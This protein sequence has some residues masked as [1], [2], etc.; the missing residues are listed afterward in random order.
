M[1][2]AGLRGNRLSARAFARIGSGA[3]LL[4]LLSLAAY[5][6][7]AYW[8][9]QAILA[10][11]AIKALGLGYV[12]T[13][14][15]GWRVGVPVFSLLF[16]TTIPTAEELLGVEEHSR[17]ALGPE[18]LLF[19]AAG[20]GAFAA[21][22]MGA[23][24]I[25]A[26]RAER[27]S[28]VRAPRPAGPPP[29]FAWLM[30]G[31]GAWG[32]GYTMVFGYYGGAAVSDAGVL[33]GIA[34]AAAAFFAAGLAVAWTEGIATGN[35]R[36]LKIAGLGTALHALV[37]LLSASKGAALFP[38]LV[39]FFC[40]VN[41]RAAVPWKPVAVVVAAYVLVVFPFATYWRAQLG[42]AG[43]SRSEFAKQGIDILLEG[44]WLGNEDLRTKAVRSG[45]RGL[46]SVY[47][48]I[49][50]ETGIVA[51]HEGGDTY[52]LALGV[53]V[54]RL[55]WP[56]KPDHNGANLVGKKY[57][58]I[59]TSD[60]ATGIAPTWAGEAAM[61]F[62]PWGIPVFFAL[63]G[64][65]AAWMDGAATRSA[66]LWFAAWMAPVAIFGQEGLVAGALLPGLRNALAAMLLLAL[67]RRFASGRSRGPA[68]LGFS[69]GARG[70]FT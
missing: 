13:G 15:V 22:S 43:G 37:G 17:G 42:E 5:S 14:F 44:A 56:G 52:L 58:I 6:Q 34:N 33:S 65:L 10:A 50:R 26:R 28:G 23:A 38:L 4:L 60:D 21:T 12:A 19:L 30:L 29:V 8:A 2:L 41:V 53:M 48:T 64:L 49:I 67:V 63:F 51:S 32:I 9:S 61:N 20:L 62:G 16:I 18:A 54:P 55:L 25:G 1:N 11:V 40:Y 59:S 70:H 66:G 45:S 35:R 47:G 7:S 27:A 46:A 39:P 3:L 24:A 31:L 36:W 68:S 69:G 57:G